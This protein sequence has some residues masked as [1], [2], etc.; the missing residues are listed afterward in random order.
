[1]DEAAGIARGEGLFEGIVFDAG[2]RDPVGPKTYFD[3]N[4]GFG[5]AGRAGLALHANTCDAPGEPIPVLGPHV[6]SAPG[7]LQ[8]HN[9]AMG[10]VDIGV[11]I[12][13]RC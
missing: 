5:P 1:V 7:T 13:R 4:N 3:R 6:A 10:A 9:A 12:R 8:V 2:A 11:G